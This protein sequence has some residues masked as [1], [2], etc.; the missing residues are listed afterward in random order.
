MWGS[1]TVQPH[2]ALHWPR[3]RQV[4]WRGKE[5]CGGGVVRGM[6]GLFTQTVGISE[7]LSSTDN[8]LAGCSASPGVPWDPHP[9]QPPAPASQPR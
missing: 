4:G 2:K 5:G 3:V 7:R 8:G 1:E 6:G 9:L